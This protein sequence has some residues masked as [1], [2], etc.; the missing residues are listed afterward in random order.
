M[1]H[2]GA[3]H[4][5]SIEN[6]EQDNRQSERALQLSRKSGYRKTKT[7]RRDAAESH[8]LRSDFTVSGSGVYNCELT[9]DYGMSAAKFNGC[10]HDFGIQFKQSGVWV[11]LQ[12]V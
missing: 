4:G 12:R 7:D 6:G 5:Q 8:I 9:K 11:L 10:L 3:G 2:A 1:E